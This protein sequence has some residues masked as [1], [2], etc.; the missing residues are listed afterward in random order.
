MSVQVSFLKTH[1][2]WSDDELEEE[3]VHQSGENPQLN[4]AVYWNAPSTLGSVE[5]AFT[6]FASARKDEPLAHL[7]IHLILQR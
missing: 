5:I 4:Y 2:G 1:F 3:I 7:I 6:R